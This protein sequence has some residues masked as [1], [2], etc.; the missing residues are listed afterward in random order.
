LAGNK[1]EIHALLENS[2]AS[3]YGQ[4]IKKRSVTSFLSRNQKN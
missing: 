3:S 1:E 4:L 2:F